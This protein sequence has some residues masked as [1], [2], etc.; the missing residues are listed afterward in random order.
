LPLGWAEGKRLGRPQRSR[1]VIEHPLWPKERIKGELQ[2]KDL[3][4]I[5]QIEASLKRLRALKG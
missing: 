1:P 5:G 4:L 3:E 2:T